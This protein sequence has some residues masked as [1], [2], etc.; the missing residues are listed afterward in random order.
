VI[1]SPHRTLRWFNFLIALS[2]LLPPPTV[3]ASSSAQPPVTVRTS[4]DSSVTAGANTGTSDVSAIQESS[5]SAA[6]MLP[7]TPAALRFYLPAAPV[8]FTVDTSVAQPVGTR[9]SAQP[10]L[11]DASR[12][13]AKVLPAMLTISN[14]D[15]TYYVMPPGSAGA[16]LHF[17]LK[18]IGLRDAYLGYID[19]LPFFVNPP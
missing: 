19:P 2:L 16:H 14:T 4:T 15:G 18:R 5:A 3:L 6:K 1:S 12:P 10:S 13:Q 8:A 11:V 9:A 17:G 7:V